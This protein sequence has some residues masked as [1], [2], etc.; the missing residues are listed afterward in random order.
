MT[1]AHWLRIY[2][3]TQAWLAEQLGVSPARVSQAFALRAR[4]TRALPPRWIPR[5]LEITEGGGGD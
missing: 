4:G 3:H 1:L 5:V 2:G